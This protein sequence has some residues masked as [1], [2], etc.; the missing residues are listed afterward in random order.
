M[1]TLQE[2]TYYLIGKQ[3][4]THI[5]SK[6]YV[7]WAVYA[8]ENGYDSENL[9]ILAGLDNA[10][11][12]DRI[13]YF[14]NSIEDLNLSFPTDKTK[15][16]SDFTK[17]LAINVINGKVKPQEGLRIMLDIVVASDYDRRFVQFMDLDEDFDYVKYSG[18]ALFNSDVTMDNHDEMV[19]NEFKLFLDTEPLN[20]N[21]R[22]LAYC[23]D[24]N[25]AIKPIIKRN[26]SI[27]KK[28]RYNYFCCPDCLSNVLKFGNNQEGKRL[29]L[30]NIKNKTGTN[31]R[32]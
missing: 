9:R 12:E 18:K 21:I 25:K 17:A 16:L 6:D 27:F 13:K 24:C 19:I 10:D 14:N 11:T 4:F 28:G 15:I 2:T 29:I 23:K 1:T 26:F 22:E 3:I 5:D 7:D 20:I 32:S 8:L 31:T 30:E